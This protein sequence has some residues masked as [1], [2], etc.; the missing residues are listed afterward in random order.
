MTDTEINM[1]NGWLGQMSDGAGEN[2]SWTS[3]YWEN[4]S[5]F[6]NENGQSIVEVDDTKKPFCN[7][8]DDEIKE[9]LC[10]RF[11]FIA[12]DVENICGMTT[13]YSDENGLDYPQAIK[14]AN[15]IVE[16]LSGETDHWEEVDEDEWKKS[17]E[18]NQSKMN[19]LN[20]LLCQDIKKLNEKMDAML[21]NKN[22][23]FG[24]DNSEEIEK[25]LS[26]L[27]GIR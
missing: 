5:N 13:M 9:D 2:L 21:A 27:E 20:Y 17:C 16:K 6:Y 25:L 18:E 12:E 10:E 1:L 22:V 8:S 23:D 26:E 3:K 4:M 19:R 24:P 7:K 11:I 14:D 15:S